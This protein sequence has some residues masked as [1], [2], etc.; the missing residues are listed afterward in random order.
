MSYGSI[1]VLTG[2]DNFQKIYDQ[3]SERDKTL[4]MGSY[5]KYR[6][7]TREIAVKHGFT[8]KV[9]AAVFAALSPNNDYW[10]NLR[11][12]DT[13]LAAAAAKRSVDSVKVSTYGNNKRKAWSIA[14]GEDPDQL[15]VA[16]KTRNFFHNIWEPDNPNYVTIDGHMAN[17][18]HGVRRPIQSK[19]NKDRVVKVTKWDYL[20]IAAAVRTFAANYEMLPC[21]I[22]GILWITW[23]RVHGIR[24]PAQQE[25][26]DRDFLAAN[27]G[28]VCS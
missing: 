24:T 21:Q 23:R 26:W 9:G 16:L 10:G 18:Y 5:Y 12:V 27:L 13:L 3:A 14:Q 2:V 6:R 8:C 1:A 11:D 15:I 25:L 22:Q 7:L 20:E 28:F 17:V 19:N 4:A